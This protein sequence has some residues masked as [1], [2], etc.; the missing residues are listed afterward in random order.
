[1]G[2]GKQ[3]WRKIK[4]QK[5]GKKLPKNDRNREEQ[6]KPLMVSAEIVENCTTTI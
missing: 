1:M 4:L 3:K 6:H 2:R 5:T